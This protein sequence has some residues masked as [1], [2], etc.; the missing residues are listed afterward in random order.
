MQIF[1]KF[2]RKKRSQYRV[3]D[4]NGTKSKTDQSFRDESNINNIMKKYDKTQVLYDPRQQ[5]FRQPQFGDFSEIPNFQEV[6]NLMI[7]ADEAFLTLPSRVREKFGNDVEKMIAWLKD[8]NNRDEAIEIGL[9]EKEVLKNNEK[10]EKI[11][12]EGSNNDS[13]NDPGNSSTN[14]KNS[15]EK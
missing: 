12:V 9:I 2:K 10:V 7:E 14:T 5:S 13:I 15:K 1:N 4:F 6:R 3:V 11:S 8:E